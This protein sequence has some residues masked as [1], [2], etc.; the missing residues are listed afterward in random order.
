MAN[1]TGRKA[2]QN[3]ATVAAGSATDATFSYYTSM[4]D[5]RKFGLQLEWTAG[6]GGGTIAVTVEGSLQKAT[7]T[8][9]S[10]ALAYQDITSATFGVASWTG[11]FI[12]MDNTEKTACLM[13]I[14]VKVVVANK[15][16]STAW[17]LDATSVA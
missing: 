11:D 8:V 1:I 13:W 6:A 5:F 15:D 7:S 12:A 3:L 4:K 10:S 17:T 14:K 9:A 16:A 2:Y